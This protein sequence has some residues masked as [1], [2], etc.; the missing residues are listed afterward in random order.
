MIQLLY[1]KNNYNGIIIS[2]N[3]YFIVTIILL[4]I[5]LIYF[6]DNYFNLILNTYENEFYYP[7]KTKKIKYFFVNY[8]NLILNT[9]ENEFY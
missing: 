8:F 9:Y 5:M 2:L 7:N 1:Y 3:V 6:F 4:K